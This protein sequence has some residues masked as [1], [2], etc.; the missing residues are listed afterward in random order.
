MSFIDLATT[1]AFDFHYSIKPGVSAPEKD[2]HTQL[3]F[4]R[5]R[6][7]LF[8]GE[9]GDEEKVREYTCVK[10]KDLN[11]GHDLELSALWMKSVYQTSPQA[12]L[13][14]VIVF[15]DDNCDEKN[16]TMA[17]AADIKETKPGEKITL[18]CLS[19]SWTN[20]ILV[21]YSS[22]RSILCIR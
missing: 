20:K 1:A 10:A 17:C 16:S 4:S 5:A 14:W 7:Y 8:N 13:A 12:S 11:D 15:A 18:D 22:H 3:E 9:K 19:K 21:P 6:S 2:Y